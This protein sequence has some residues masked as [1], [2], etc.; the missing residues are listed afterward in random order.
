M[1]TV[2]TYPAAKPAGC[3]DLSCE[4]LS[5]LAETSLG[6]LAH[7]KTAVL[8]LGYL[9]GWM[10]ELTE[11]TKL[12]RVLRGFECHVI[13]REPF[14]FSQSWKNEI[15]FIYTSPVHGDANTD[16]HGGTVHSERSSGHESTTR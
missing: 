3:F 2:Y 15:D 11:E 5:T 8:W 10:L 9:E 12:R 16:N 6:I 4:P 13:S 1:L 14:S 7:H